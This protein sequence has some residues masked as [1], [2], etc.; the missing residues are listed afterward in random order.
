MRRHYEVGRGHRSQQASRT[1]ESE[2][3]SL[4]AVSI[5]KAGGLNGRQ[6][7]VVNLLLDTTYSGILDSSMATVNCPRRSDKVPSWRG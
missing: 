6:T 2:D 5:R 7:F 4:G 1:K 3:G